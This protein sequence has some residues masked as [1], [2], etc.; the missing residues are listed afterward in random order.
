MKMEDKI[1]EL[2]AEYLKKTDQTLE[3]IEETNK[4]IDQSNKRMDLAYGILVQHS[5][6]LISLRKEARQ[7]A[8]KREVQQEAL[9]KEIFSISKRVGNLEDKSK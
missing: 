2:L 5:E 8:L 6:E 9:L 4:R 7:E 3:S 1:L